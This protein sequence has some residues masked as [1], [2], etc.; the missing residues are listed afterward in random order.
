VLVFSERDKDATMAGLMDH[1]LDHDAHVHDYRHQH[2]PRD[3][4]GNPVYLVLPDALR[5]Q[6]E[7][8]MR[9]CEAAWR[10]GEPLAVAEATTCAHLYRQPVPA[11]LE[12][13]VVGLA[14]GRRS[15]LQ[16]KRY[17]A[18]QIRFWRHMTVRDLKLD[19]DFSTGKARRITEISWE[20]AFERAAELLAKT[21][22]AGSAATMR[23]DYCVVQG[24]L[25][26]G[27][28]GLSF[29]LKDRRYRL[30]GNPDPTPRPKPPYGASNDQDNA[31]G[32]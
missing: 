8:Q 1:H 19:I 22:M 29:N 4:K 23:R 17:T 5:V 32:K 21:P 24:D 7:E 12:Q 3:D 10:E 16:A 14:M 31:R 30:N 25:N 6:Y 28:F 13:A 27:R 15:P 18:A 11:W 9:L 20:E 2:I 26:A